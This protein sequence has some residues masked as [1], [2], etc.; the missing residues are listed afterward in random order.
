MRIN[1]KIEQL[2]PD[3]SIIG[4]GVDVWEVLRFPSD[5]LPVSSCSSTL[6]ADISISANMWTSTPGSPGLSRRI[7]PTRLCCG[8]DEADGT[9]GK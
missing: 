3:V 7:I 9:F 8:R 2:D 5:P 1:R 6:A 4:S